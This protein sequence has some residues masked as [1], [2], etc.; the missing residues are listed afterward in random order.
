MRK[1]QIGEYQNPRSTLQLQTKFSNCIFKDN[2]IV[3]FEF[4]ISFFTQHRNW[5]RT[6]LVDIVFVLLLNYK[7]L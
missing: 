4:F 2:K 7:N 5:R 3:P 1:K 6:H